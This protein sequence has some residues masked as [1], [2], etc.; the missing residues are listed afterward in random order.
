LAS[1]FSIHSLGV[2]SVMITHQ[3]SAG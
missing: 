1:C 3:H 2:Y